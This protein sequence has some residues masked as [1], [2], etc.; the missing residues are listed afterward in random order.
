MSNKVVIDIEARLIDRV[1]GD[2]KK[3]EKNIDNLEKKAEKA[4]KGLNDLGKTTAKPKVEANTSKFEKAMNKAQKMADKFGRTKSSAVLDAVDKASSKFQKV[5]SKFKEFGGKT[6]RSILSVHDSNA[7]ST[8]KKV[9]NAGRGIAGATWRATVSI[10]D[11]ATSPLRRIKD[12][13]FSIKGLVTAI[14]AGFATQQAVFKPISVA[15]AYSGAKIGFSTLL[16]GEA[17]GQAMMDDLDAFAKKTPF[18]TTGV[19]ANA[20][21]MMAM[22]WDANSILGDMEIIGNAAA[23]TGKMDVGLE[24]IVRAMAQIK[25]KGK[26]SAEELNQLAEAGI[27]AKGMLAEELGYG[28]GDKA[29]AAFS[30]DQEDGKIGADKALDALL[31]GMEKKYSGMMESMANETA[32]GLISQ[33]KDVFEINIVRRW[34]QGLQEGAKQGLGSILKLLD[35]SEKGLETLGDTLFELGSEISSKAAKGLDNVIQKILTISE[36]DEFKNASLSDKFHIVWDEVV[37][38]PL[39]AWWEGTGKAKVAGI[40]EKI[41]AGL[42]TGIGNVFKG[43]FGAADDVGDG[44]V[45]IG[46]SFA[47]GFL[48]G[49][50]AKGVANSIYESFKSFFKEHPIAGALLGA[51]IVNKTLAP[52]GGTMAVAGA[53]RAA[54]KG[55]G[56]VAGILGSTGNAMVGGSGLLGMF[57]SAGYGLTGGAAASTLAGGTAAAIGG[58]SILGGLLGVLGIGSG[59]K[60]LAKGNYWS[61]GTK[62]GLVGSGAAAGAAIGSVI[63]GL[64]T[65]VGGL[66]GAGVGGLGALLGGDAIGNALSNLGETLSTFFKETLPEKWDSL[67]ESV[68][69]F[70]SETVPYAIGYAAG[71]TVRFFT[72]T[73]PEKWDSLWENVGTF[74][75]DTLPTWASNVWS[76]N[77]CPFFTED[78][79]EFFSTLWD[80]VCEFVT[81]GIPSIASSI[82]SNVSG[83]FTETVPGWFNSVWENLKSGFSAGKNGGGGGSPGKKATGG[84]IQGRQL[85]W[86]GEEGTPEMVIPLGANRRKRGIELWAQAGRYLGVR[87]YATGGVAGGTPRQASPSGAGGGAVV[88]VTVGDINLEVKAEGGQSALDSIKAQKQ[89]L[90]DEIAEII[91]QAIEAMYQNMPVR[92]GA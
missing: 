87:G 70:F 83:F 71:V 20:Q 23:A 51:H 8:I 73:L 69:S 76:N 27:S 68:G 77:I 74:F 19:I 79:P 36:S 85:S 52:F 65:A 45:T 59:V 5:H 42:G 47:K 1:S 28:T 44:A 78:I 63:P 75:T 80:D 54:L 34:G 38:E 3:V 86:L 55:A 43:L 57:A 53:G 7:M 37:A 15:D 61:G 14:T 10:A 49:F 35:K 46:S 72:E 25:T 58:G 39:E 4:R 24:S 16:G 30:K 13:L 6:Y 31:R 26:L 41:G 91:N 11:M 82:W 60:D 62:L 50:D 81:E 29:L 88:N 2:A 64:G 92:G 84:L 67:W 66:I 90:A 12:S 56:G 40:A 9:L 22:G 21:K 18:N 17:Q 33:I 32:E 89:Q 48:D